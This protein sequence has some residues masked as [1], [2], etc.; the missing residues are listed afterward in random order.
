[1]TAANG[2]RVA[3]YLRVSTAGQTVENQRRELKAVAKRHGWKIITVFADEGVSGAQ[4]REG[5]PGFD[6]LMMA[7]SR[8]EVDMVAAWSVDRLGRSLKHLV[9]FLGEIHSKGIDL[10]LHQQGLD[11]STPAG[12]ALFGMMSV[13]AEFERSIIVERVKSGL[14]RAKAEGKKLGRRPVSADKEAAVRACLG[15]GF[16][17]I[18]TAKTCGVGVSV[19]QRIKASVCLIELR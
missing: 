17:L 5:R 13:F 10:Y 6:A 8:R 4:G 18:K 7:V 3:L 2:K 11:T 19:V 16:G 9:D 12:R 14:A 1:M 15:Q